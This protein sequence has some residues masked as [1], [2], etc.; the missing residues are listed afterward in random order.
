MK[1]L[2]LFVLCVVAQAQAANICD[3]VLFDTEDTT[4]STA[5]TGA[6]DCNKCSN[7]GCSGRGCTKR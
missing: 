7:R 5:S 2:F 4:E 3:A 1:R 6:R